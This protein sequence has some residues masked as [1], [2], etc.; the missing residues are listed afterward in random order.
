MAGI[1]VRF[2]ATTTNMEGNMDL[3]KLAPWNWFR[4]E[5]EANAT[6]P[7]RHSE[8][9][10]RQPFDPVSHFQREMNNLFESAFRGF[11]LSPFGADS[12]PLASGIILKPRVDIS[13]TDNEY[14]ITAEVPG[15]SEQDLKL[16]IAD[17]VLT[18]SGEKKQDKED[19]GESYYRMERSYGSFQRVLTLPEDAQHQ[20]VTATFKKGVLTVRMPRRAL[21][22][23]QVKKIEIKSG[24]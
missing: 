21:P 13:A 7:S 6:V 16:E 3:K 15:V 20:E 10:G 23:A 19:R 11:G 1:L 9:S 18:I 17:N 22:N 24:D 14:C 8:A 5:E 4:H 12:T 2:P